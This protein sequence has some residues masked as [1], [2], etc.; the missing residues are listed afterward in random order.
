M[1]CDIHMMIEAK[2]KTQKHGDVWVTV[3]SLNAVYPDG[4][5]RADRLEDSPYG[6]HYR[7]EMRNYHFFA[8][9][10]CV[11]GEGEYQ[12]RGLPDDVSAL[13]LAYSESWGY[14]G[15]SHSYLYADE[16]IPLYIKHHLSDEEK[17]KLVSDRMSGGLSDI[18]VFHLIMERHFNIA[19]REE[20]NPQDYRFVFFFDN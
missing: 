19:T 11:R 14:D 13:A 4:L 16:M 15:H 20:D 8:D 10:A 5:V 18:Q 6:Y 1:G 2:A 7:I 3:N 17:A 12:D 9:I